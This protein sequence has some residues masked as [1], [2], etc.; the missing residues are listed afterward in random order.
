MNVHWREHTRT[1]TRTRT[2]LH[3]VNFQPNIE[4]ILNCVHNMCKSK[5]SKCQLATLP[6]K[7]TELAM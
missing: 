5:L 2:H 1:R 7:Y 4:S 3:N 6:R